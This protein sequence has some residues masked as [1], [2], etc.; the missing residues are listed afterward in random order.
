MWNAM[1]PSF[2]KPSPHSAM[3]TMFHMKRFWSFWMKHV[4]S[5]VWLA[6]FSQSVGF[7]SKPAT[8]RQ[9][10]LLAQQFLSSEKTAADRWDFQFHNHAIIEHVEEK[11]VTLFTHVH[12]VSFDFFLVNIW[13]FFIDLFENTCVHILLNQSTFQ[14]ECHTWWHNWEVW[15]YLG[16][17]QNICAALQ[18]E[19]TLASAPR[20][21][22]CQILVCDG[23]AIW[24]RWKAS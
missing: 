8:S 9:S 23:A 1:S 3:A 7:I 17:I 15:H 10:F 18:Q 13:L 11:V 19:K 22:V 2:P 12:E 5:T 20:N 24:M 6:Q 16:H 21:G 14:W 4:L